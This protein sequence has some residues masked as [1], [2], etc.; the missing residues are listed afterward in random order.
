[1]GAFSD[2]DIALLETFAN[3]AVIAIQNARLFNET[4]EALEQQ[5]ATAEVLQ[6]ISS[7]IA[8]TGPVFDKILD[9]C[10][11]LFA[12]D[13]L[14]VMLLGDDGR[15]HARAGRGSAFDALARDIGSMPLETTFTGRAIR[16]R[17]TVR[18]TEA[19]MA[20]VAHP[21]ARR[22]AESLGPYTA[23]YS[24]MIWEGR[25]VGAICI[26]RQPPRPFADKE[27]ALL[28]TFADQAVIAIQNA[29]LF[30]ETKEALE[31][32]TATA[33]VLQVISS[34][35][36][37]TAPVFD[38]ILESGQHL[39]ATEQLG[40]FLIKDDGQVH[41]AAWRGKALEAVARTFPKPVEHTMTARVIRERRTVHAPDAGA[42]PGAPAAVQGVVDL[43]GNCSVAWAPMIW[44]G[45]GVGSI[46]VLRQPPKPFTDKELAL[47]Q[48]FG[49]QAVIAIENA[50]L[51]NDTK[52]ALE[53]QTATADVLKVISASPTDVQPVFDAIATSAATLCDAQFCHVFQYDGALVHFVAEHGLAPE[54][55]ETLR[56]A[57]PVAPGRASAAARAIL[58]RAIEEI[59]DVLADPDYQHG[60]F[61]RTMNFRGIVAVPMLRD[62]APIGAIALSQSKAG[63]FSARQIDLLKTFADQ[64]VIAIENVRLFNE[65][66]D[67]LDRQTATA[68]VLK[69]ISGSVADT[70]PVFEKILDSCR[71]LFAS[72]QLGIFL[73]G[74]DNR[75]R[76]GEWH[77]SASDGIPRARRA[78]GGGDFHG[79]GHPRTAH[80]P[81]RRRRGDRRFAQDRGPGHG[82]PRQLLGHLQSD[83]VGGQGHRL[84]VRLPP[85]AP[86]FQRRGSGAA[87]HLRR[88]GGDR[89][90]ERAS[91]QRDQGSARASDGDFR[92]SACDQRVP[93]R[94]AT[95]A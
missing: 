27:V 58:S 26:F 63:R 49:D 91:V 80:D 90:P 42:I 12:T 50:R 6:V 38:K 3:Q 57:Y 53:Q 41:A 75:V 40:I 7:S 33:E 78:S 74:D 83:D 36:A 93:D 10:Q 24:P 9:S 64:A 32:Q 51:F 68:E 56:R 70:A 52:E 44:E 28:E 35:V 39:F 71:R 19:D 86:A 77:G 85:A 47:L 1:M 17:R 89:D 16:E 94:R 60:D 76:V 67:A 11:H 30:N 81:G 5:T 23:I 37:D 59:P 48:T 87:A 84:A 62:G 72:E 73:V 95:G 4:Q 65:T 20:T 15:V 43:I 14:G 55:V 79:A 54:A 61:A 29:R 88:P 8:D 21:A 25:G 82:N 46:T 13:Q 18:T 2:K 92:G 34:S 31:Q 22:L 45:K 66:K 69:V